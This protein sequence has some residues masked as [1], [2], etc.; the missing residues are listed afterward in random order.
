MCGRA[1]ERAKVENRKE[2]ICR[3]RKSRKVTGYMKTR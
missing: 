3:I 1:S 2:G